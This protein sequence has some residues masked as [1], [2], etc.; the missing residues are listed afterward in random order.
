MA[1]LTGPETY[2]PPPLFIRAVQTRGCQHRI[3]DPVC[4]P[5]NHMIYSRVSFVF[6]HTAF[7]VYRATLVQGRGPWPQPYY[8]TPIKLYDTLVT[9]RL[10]YFYREPPQRGRRIHCLTG[11]D[12][13][14]D[15]RV[16]TQTRY[17]T[18]VHNI[19]AA[20]CSPTSCNANT[21]YNN[22]DEK[23]QFTVLIPLL[24]LSLAAGSV[25]YQLI[26]TS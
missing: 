25:H 6:A 24:V 26:L 19:A 16:T 18:T 15:Y 8:L 5:I 13:P 12:K 9:G 20:G 7:T 3:T 14:V 10:Y 22:L 2:T 4:P 11:C 17:C 21:P 1:H 23:L